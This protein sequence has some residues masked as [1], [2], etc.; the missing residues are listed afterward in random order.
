MNKKHRKTLAAIFTT[1]TKANIRFA[2]IESL[3]VS[4]GGRITEGAGS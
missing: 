3:L 4:L 2:N 1:P